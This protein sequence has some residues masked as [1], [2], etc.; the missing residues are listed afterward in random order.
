MWKPFAPKGDFYI[1]DT[2]AFFVPRFGSETV[3]FPLWKL[4]NP[5]LC[6]NAV[7]R[8]KKNVKNAEKIRNLL[9]CKKSCGNIMVYIW[10]KCHHTVKSRV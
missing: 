4:L 3:F 1:R 9:R 6:A 5:K 7:K 2:W 10:H 8:N